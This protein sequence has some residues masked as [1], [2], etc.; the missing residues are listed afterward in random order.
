MNGTS[1]LR[2]QPSTYRSDLCRKMSTVSL[3]VFA[4]C[5]LVVI[6]S[7]SLGAKKRT[8]YVE[9]VEDMKAFKKL[10]KTRL[11]VLVLFSSGDQSVKKFY[12]VFDKVATAMAGQGTM[13]YVNCKDKK[14]MCKNLKVFPEKEFLL[15]HYMNGEFHKDYDR[16]FTEKSLTG[17]MQNP[18]QDAPWSEDPVSKDI[19][20]LETVDD[21]TGLLRSEPK[22]ILVMFYAPWCGHCKALKP[23]FAEAATDLK[24]NAVLAGMDVEKQELY[25]LRQALNITGFPTIHYYHRGEKLYDYNGERTKE[26]IVEWM[27]NPS[28]SKVP[29]ESEESWSE[30]E[31]EVVHLTAENF[32]D[33]LSENPS[34]LVMFYAPWCGHCKAMKPHYTAAADQLKRDGVNGVLAAVDATQA[35]ELAEKYEVKGFPT[36]KYFKDGEYLY[37]YGYDRKTEAIVEFMKDPKEPPPPPPPEPEWSDTPSEVNHLDEENF[38]SFLKK[39]KHSLVMFYAPWCGHCKA[40]K[41]H[42][43]AA[44]EAFKDQKKKAFAAVDCTKSN[45]LC[46]QHGV[47]GFPT[48]KYFHYGKKPADYTGGRTEE[49]FR[50]FME[51]PD[52]FIRRTEL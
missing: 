21:F 12:P 19:K 49:D 24:P 35:R 31:S 38:S 27:K 30:E 46:S 8:D 41:P 34:V 6:V 37:E 4:L 44:A 26:G 51:N 43:T 39:K 45:D 3:R 23:H 22:P 20:H 47:Q 5:A 11:N 7:Q 29:E 25:G 13:I 32:D 10:I 9:K 18:T 16:S 36:V 14:K 17:F 52:Q 28:A 42:Y 48:F 40:A 33:V 2:L 50:K 15:K 1:S